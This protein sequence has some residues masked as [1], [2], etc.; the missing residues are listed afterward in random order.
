MRICC[1]NRVDLSV[2]CG[3]SWSLELYFAAKKLLART[4]NRVELV[5]YAK[6][7]TINL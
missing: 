3:E 1:E 4:G 7:I 5:E 2:E 6:F